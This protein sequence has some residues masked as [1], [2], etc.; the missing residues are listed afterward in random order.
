M[1]AGM[2][3][4]IYSS[5]H[6]HT[7]TDSSPV[8]DS[9]SYQDICVHVP[10]GPKYIIYFLTILCWNYLYTRFIVTQADSTILLLYVEPFVPQTRELILLI[11]KR[12]NCH[13]LLY[14]MMK[15]K[16][17]LV[18]EDWEMRREESHYKAC[19]ALCYFGCSTYCNFMSG[20]F[21]SFYVSNVFV[22]FLL[23]YYSSS[24]SYACLLC[25]GPHFCRSIVHNDTV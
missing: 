8:N 5:K 10:L 9:W 20:F 2:A 13:C 25:R 12:E 3:T 18:R 23:T 11:S 22:Y 19:F 15:R 24:I 7:V 14:S 21:H 1:P 17:R 16:R 4:Y 6:A